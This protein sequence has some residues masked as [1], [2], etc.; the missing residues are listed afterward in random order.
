MDKPT[1]DWVAKG[2]Q[3][4]GYLRQKQDHAGAIADMVASV[5]EVSQWILDTQFQ[6][7]RVYKTQ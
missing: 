7:E 2:Q 1:Q 3:V 5:P 6:W 4:Y